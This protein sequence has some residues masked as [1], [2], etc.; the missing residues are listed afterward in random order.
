MRPMR[1]LAGY[2]EKKQAPVLDTVDQ[3]REAAVPAQVPGRSAGDQARHDDAECARVAAGS[4]TAKVAEAIVHFLAT[5]GKVTHTN[6]MRQHVNRGEHAVPLDRLPRLP[7][8]A[9]RPSQPPLPTS[10]VL[11]TPSRKYTLPGLTQ[12]LENPLAVRPGGRMPHLNLS[13]A[14]ARDIASFLLNDLDIAAGLQYAYYEGTWDKL[15]DFSKLTPKADR[16]RERFRRRR[17][18]GAR[19]TSPCASTAR[20]SSTRTATICS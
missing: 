13:P 5:T 1:S 11:G 12:F 3:P 9:Q 4:G 14:D 8:S 16:R 17:R 20:S 6:P 10:I 7:R 15:P 19:T 18:Q 2:V